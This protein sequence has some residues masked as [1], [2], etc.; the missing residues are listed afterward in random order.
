MNPAAEIV[1]G[2]LAAVYAVKTAYQL[3]VGVSHFR[4]GLR[5][6]GINISPVLFPDPFLILGITWLSTGQ[7]DPAL[8]WPVLLVVLT[9]ITVG[10]YL[11]W[12]LLYRAGAALGSRGH[13][14]NGVSSR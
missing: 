8:P 3:A 10:S 13:H 2:V 9:A 12:G 14:P 1:F 7:P 5:G 11:S 6:V 4:A